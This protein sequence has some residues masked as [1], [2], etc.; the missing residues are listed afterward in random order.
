MKQ[1]LPIEP[2]E[3]YDMRRYFDSK[4]LDLCKYMHVVSQYMGEN[5]HKH[6]LGKR[7]PNSEK[8]Q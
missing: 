7:N 1:F 6:R 5:G 4:E 2:K 8:N 3:D